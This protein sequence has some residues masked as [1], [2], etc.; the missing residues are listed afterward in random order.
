MKN[1]PTTEELIKRI[2]EL[3]KHEESFESI[4]RFNRERA[5]KLNC[6]YSISRIVEDAGQDAD[7]IMQKV[8][9]IIPPAWQYPEITCTKINLHKSECKTANFK[10]TK[11]M[12]SSPITIHGEKAGMLEVLYIKEKPVLDEGPFLR[13][14]RDLINAIAERVGR[15]L[16]RIESEKMLL[17][18]KN[19]VEGSKDFIAA[20]DRRYRYLFAN[21]AYL[22]FR[23][24]KKEDVIGSTIEEDVGKK[25]FEKIF[26]GNLDRVFNEKKG[27]TDS[28]S[29]TFKK[30]I[31]DS[32]SII[33]ND[34]DTRDLE[35]RYE[36]VERNGSDI[37]VVIIGRDVTEQA[38]AN[39]R[40]KNREIELQEKTNHLEEV[41]VAL[42]VLVNQRNEDRAEFG[43]NV[44]LN[45]KELINPYIEKL[46]TSGLN[47]SQKTF[48]EIIE[49]NLTNIISPFIG[50][51]SSSHHSLTPMEIKVASLVKDGKT[52]KE[53]A[54]LLNLSL[55]TIL[56]HRHHIRNKFGLKNKKI[57]LRT[58]L[59]SLQ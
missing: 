21:R 12:M 53:I 22:N 31:T 42:K 24:M 3:E 28:T 56:T 35:I 14:E 45:I 44:I 1:E 51:L 38:I 37:R 33:Y 11:W 4:T 43:E 29:I 16:E 7:R 19:A 6:L 36:P 41:N 34:S 9:N 13:E 5:K 55:S 54:D 20:V 50:K 2:E 25:T 58:H 8:V 10:R 23:N 48:I 46:K 15:I 39:R 59:L 30:T 18:Y 57:N 49:T 40:I 52:N 26:K 17:E 32:T 47:R 27:V